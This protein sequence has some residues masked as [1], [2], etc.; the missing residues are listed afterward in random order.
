MQKSAEAVPMTRHALVCSVTHYGDHQLSPLNS[1]STR[2]LLK[3]LQDAG[4]FQSITCLPNSTSEFT[5]SGKALGQALRHFLLT[6]ASGQDG[7]VYISSYGITVEDDLGEPQGFLL[8]SEGAV[9]WDGQTLVAQRNGISLDSL[10]G[11]IRKSNLNRLIVLWDCCH[12]GFGLTREVLERSLTAFNEKPNY[13]FITTA[14]MPTAIATTEIPSAPVNLQSG[15]FTQAL[16]SV[17][18]S[19]QADEVG[20]IGGDRLFAALTTQLQGTGASPLRLSTSSLAIVTYPTM[21]PGTGAPPLASS[22]QPTVTNVFNISDST[23]TNVATSGNINYTEGAS[24]IR[25]VSASGGSIQINLSPPS[26]EPSANKPSANKPSAKE[27]SAASADPTSS[28]SPIAEPSSTVPATPQPNNREPKLTGPIE[29]F[30]SYSHRDEALRDEVAKHLSILQRQGVISAWYDRDIEAGSEWAADI[31]EHLNLAQ[32]ILLLI[33]PDFL[34]S[35]YCFDLEM[36]RAMER[37]EAR[38]AYVIPVIVRPV[39][40]SGAPFS[41]L[42]ALP[43]NAKAVTRWSNR[44]EAFED[45]AKGIRKLVERLSAP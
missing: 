36:K 27:P 29:V 39:D 35:D 5:V 34:A 9:T 14:L 43:K 28:L 41:K 22:P 30:F 32:V 13:C 8:P 42:Q 17:L 23:L 16:L 18:V 37:H 33:S 4:Y 19:D 25:N 1:A 11:L 10:N 21:P 20:Q 6:Q 3:R 12:Q 45:V 7:V 40:W 31:D 44:D 2:A 38:E 15:I 26:T 24:Q